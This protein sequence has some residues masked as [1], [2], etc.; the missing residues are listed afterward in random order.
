[1][2]TLYAIRIGREP[3]HI[4][5]PVAEWVADETVD[6]ALAGIKQLAPI[7]NSTDAKH[8]ILPA[9]YS[10]FNTK[11]TGKLTFIINSCLIRVTER[12]FNRALFLLLSAVYPSSDYRIISSNLRNEYHDNLRFRFSM[13]AIAPRLNPT[14]SA[15]LS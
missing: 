1:M 13:V 10:F 15:N 6:D 12:T 3:I 8:T 2:V 14:L 4:G 7:L 5:T 11:R 9:T